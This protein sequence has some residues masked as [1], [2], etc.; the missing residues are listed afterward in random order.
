[1]EQNRKVCQISGLYGFWSRFL[2][3]HRLKNGWRIT[4]NRKKR[5]KK[6]THQKFLHGR[7]CDKETGQEKQTSLALQRGK[8]KA[9]YGVGQKAM[10]VYHA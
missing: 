4:E 7:T 5:K 3:L 9:L 8:K 1:L 10:W 2:D 6:K